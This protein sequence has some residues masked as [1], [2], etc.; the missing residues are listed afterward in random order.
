VYYY[1]DLVQQGISEKVALSLFFVAGFISGFV[2]AFVRSWRLAIVLV[3][4]LPFMSVIGGA[5]GKFVGRYTE[6]A[7]LFLW[8]LAHRFA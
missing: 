4:M 8:G 7:F 6:Y 3:T 5:M 2:I 1:I